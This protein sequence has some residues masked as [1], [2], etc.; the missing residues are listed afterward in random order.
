MCYVRITYK[1][2]LHEYGPSPQIF[3]DRSS[4]LKDTPALYWLYNQSTGFPPL[5]SNVARLKLLPALIAEVQNDQIAIYD[6]DNNTI[7]KNKNENN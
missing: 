2:M 6:K 3:N 7:T 1:Y 4:G 5:N